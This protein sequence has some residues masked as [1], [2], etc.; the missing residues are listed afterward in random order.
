[1]YLVHHGIVV[2]LKHAQQIRPMTVLRRIAPTRFNDVVGEMRSLLR[3]D[4]CPAGAP[5]SFQIFNLL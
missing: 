5:E 3:D 4:G 1:M 2:E